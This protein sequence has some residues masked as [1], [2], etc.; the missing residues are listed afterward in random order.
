MNKELILL[1]GI[2]GSGKSTVASLITDMV[3]SADDFFTD[4]NGVYNFDASKLQAAHNWC[5]TR[6]ETQMKASMKKIVVANTFTQKWEMDDY[7]NLAAKY[8]YRVHSLIA[9]NRHGSV[10]VHNVPD[11]ALDKMRKRF[12]VKL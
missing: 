2:P 11:T 5:K 9:E 4:E 12:E 10:N 6:T 7:F 1:R 3:L 8:G